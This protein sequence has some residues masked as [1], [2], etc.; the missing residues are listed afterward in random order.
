MEELKLPPRQIITVS[1]PPP[2]QEL[3]AK[4]LENQVSLC[5]PTSSL[6]NNHHHH[7]P[8]PLCSTFPTPSI[9]HTPNNGVFGYHNR[10]PYYRSCEITSSSSSSHLP[11]SPLSPPNFLTD[12]QDQDWSTPFPLRSTSAVFYHQM[13]DEDEMEICTSP[14]TGYRISIT[15]HPI[16]RNISRDTSS[17]SSFK[18]P[19]HSD[20]QP[21][22]FQTNEAFQRN[23]VIIDELQDELQMTCV[24][25]NKST[26]IPS[27]VKHV[28][29]PPPEN[30]NTT[31]FELLLNRGRRLKRLHS[32]LQ[33]QQPF[34]LSNG[35]DCE[36]S[37]DQDND[38]ITRRRMK[39]LIN[40]GGI[41]R[42]RNILLH[43]LISPVAFD[44]A[45]RKGDG[46]D[47]RASPTRPN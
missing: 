25:S 11:S 41:S 18:H 47:E 13:N 14:S 31:A 39:K 21:N 16:S 28:P 29:P 10:S 38:N 22:G 19:R 46:D 30:I 44:D 34:S 2:S 17:S 42:R 33:L 3:D 35:G 20:Q 23:H 8:P 36:E 32:Q 27:K 37:D 5:I 9:Y 12:D 15:K 43:S 4:D 1:P 45:N 24:R 7:H 40:G 26:Y 6:Y